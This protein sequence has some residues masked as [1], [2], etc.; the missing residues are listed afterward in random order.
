MAFCLPPAHATEFKKALTDGRITPEKLMAMESADRHE[1]LAGIVGKD[2]A[3]AV[4]SLF[5]SKLMLKDQQ[6]G[7]V[8]WAK[9]LTT[10]K[11]AVKKDLL[12]KIDKLDRILNPAEEKAFL[13]DLAAT[14]LGTKV[15]FE[16]SQKIT[17]LAQKA[18][19]ER[20]KPTDQLS[21]VSNEFLKAASDLEHYVKSLKPTTAVTSIFKNFAIIARNH[22]LMNPATP[23]K[24][25]IGQIVNSAMDLVTRRIASHS[26]GGENSE[27]AAEAN[28]Q[29]WATFRETGMNTALMESY[30]D[31]GKL[32]EHANFN[33]PEGMLSAHPALHKVE[34]GV[35]WYAQKTNKIAIDLEH[36]YAFTKFY[37]KAFFDMLNIGSTNIAKSEGLSGAALKSRAA[38]IMKDAAKI[39]PETDVGA[40]I[41]MQGQKQAAR[42]TSTND[43]VIGNFALG[44]KDAINKHIANGLG[45]ALMPIAKIPANIIWNGIENAGVGL[46]TGA[47]D[48]FEGRAK[49]QSDDLKTRYEGMAQMSAGIQK[50]ARTVGVLGMA[51][52]FSSTLTKQDFRSDNYG[53]HFVKIG[54]V[55]IN[56]EY[57]S[58]ISPALAGFMTAKRDGNS[59]TGMLKEFGYYTSGALQGLKSA[60]G[61]DEASQLVTSITNRN[62]ALG[63]QKYAENFF[64]SRGVPAFFHNLDNDRPMNRLFF[65]AHGVETQPQV[66]RDNE[67]RA[68]QAAHNR[69]AVA[70]YEASP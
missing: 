14:K 6:A 44:I 4:N 22:L 24:T 13:A 43:T 11:A 10:V 70:H 45:D 39:K 50:V 51:A 23:V 62:W 17:K 9:S 54:N 53:N 63:I 1:F 41:R 31:S 61:V 46:G 52:L 30:E 18:M 7:M 32:G 27:L 48:I 59:R 19:V 29:A 66:S 35:R 49:I 69:A 5:E 56:L 2:S 38:A 26:L 21:G 60:P 57:I 65:G 36:N 67:Q 3:A 12:N 8:R 33:V 25:T 68:M 15:T 42:V 40:V 28:K 47:K 20:D 34:A 55:W 16:E 37:Q 64:T 58:A